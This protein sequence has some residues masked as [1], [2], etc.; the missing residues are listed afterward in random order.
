LEKKAV[1]GIMLTLLLISI[2]TL[3][4][5]IQPVRTSL[6]TQALPAT[7]P[8]PLN[9]TRVLLNYI[10]PLILSFLIGFFLGK[11]MKAKHV[12]AASVILWL[13]FLSIILFASPWGIFCGITIP[14]LGGGFPLSLTIDLGTEICLTIEIGFFIGYL[15]HKQK[16]KN[17]RV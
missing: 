15:K 5:D 8:M 10:F 16:V 17:I 3:A 12:V 7:I 4:F 9:L 11:K 2:L 6:G 14:R 13:I 1:S